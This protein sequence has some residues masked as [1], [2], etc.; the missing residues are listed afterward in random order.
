MQKQIFRHCLIN[1]PPKGNFY[2]DKVKRNIALIHSVIFATFILFVAGV[3]FLQLTANKRNAETAC[4]MIL[5]Q[6]EDVIID[7][8]RN[9]STLMDTLKDEYTLR[10][11][12]L[13]DILECRSETD[14]TSEDYKKLAE[15]ISVDELHIFDDTG[16]IIAGSNPEYYGYNFDSGEQISFFKPMLEDKSLTM[17]QDIVPNTAAGKPMMYAMV[18][19]ESRTEMIQIGIAPQR[20]LKIMQD[21]DVSNLIKLMPVTEG[22][23]LFVVND[24]SGEVIGSTKDDILG[25]RLTDS[26]RLTYSLNENEK[27]TDTA[28]IQGEMSYITFM[29]FDDKDLA[30]AYSVKAANNSLPY[31]LIPVFICLMSAF[32][33]ICYITGHSLNKLSK[34]EQELLA[35]K[36]AAEQANAAKEVFLSRMSHDIRTPLNGII[37]LIDINDKHADDRELVN[38]NRQKERVA[39]G[40][41]LEL[42]NDVLEFNKIGS[43]EV[44]LAY[45]PFNTIDLCTDVL[46]I[47]AAR[48]AESGINFVHEDCSANISYP[49]VFGSPLHVRQIFINIIGNAIK[50]NRKGGSVSCKTSCELRSDGRVWYTVIIADTGIGMSEEFLK[51]IYEPFSQ[52]NSDV[53]STYDGTGLG[54]SIVKQLVDKMGGTIDVKS[55]PGEGSVFTVTIPFDKAQSSDMPQKESEAEADITGINILIAEDNELN[56][57]IAD[58]LLSDAGANIT[59]ANNGEEAVRIF[60]EN[61][62][63]TFDVILM[64]IMMPVM[65]GYEAAEKIRASGKGDAQSIH[66]IAMTANAFAEDVEKALDAGMNAHIAKPLDIRKLISAVSYHAR[67]KHT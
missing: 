53:K 6:L 18:W 31:T 41:L 26:D 38:S 24:S 43:A 55:R 46:T 5:D 17:C 14:L 29:R 48:A 56:M 59:K 7:N 57:E 13:A 27:Y 47:T 60:E 34:K 11:V 66:I 63:G 19:N 8:D 64:D 44:K 65:N 1:F 9:V 37:G 39:A 67:S 49:Y 62:E 25:Y 4:S 12:M 36:E 33:V 20:L 21:S 51:H 40:H 61:P 28:K 50:Y 52:E 32:F 35:A 30:V 42:I 23:A 22:M 3:F 2:M 15:E 16:T 45:E 10:A 54:M 58:T